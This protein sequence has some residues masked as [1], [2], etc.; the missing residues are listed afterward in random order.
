MEQKEQKIS[1]KINNYYFNKAINR[2][3]SESTPHYHPHFEIYYM[4]EGSCRYFIDDRSFDVEAGDVIFIP[5]GVIHRTNYGSNVHSRLLVNFTEEYIP[6]DALPF[7]SESKYLYRSREIAKNIEELFNKVER[8]YMNTDI[9]SKSL[10]KCYTAAMFYLM[11]RYPGD[12]EEATTGNE[13]IDSIVKYIKQNYMT[14]IK[15]STVAKMKSVSQEHLSRTFKSCTGLGF[16]EYVTL[17]RLHKAEEMI[18]NEPN[19]TISDIAFECGFNDGNYFSYKFK[20]QYGVS[21]IK[22]RNNK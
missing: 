7:L 20:K 11:L 19:K 15:L 9:F 14:D 2:K 6:E 16:N 1:G 5:K 22:L 18:V 12:L 8:E 3:Y 21:P 13:L 17:L 10:F 4:K